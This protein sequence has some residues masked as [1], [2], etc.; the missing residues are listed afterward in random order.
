MQSC[1]VCVTLLS[2]RPSFHVIAQM[3]AL[4]SE[5]APSDLGGGCEDVQRY[6]CRVNTNFSEIVQQLQ[7]M[8]VAIKVRLKK[9]SFLFQSSEL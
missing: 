6:G 2:V 3:A 5:A 4:C 9:K 8:S 7:K 1:Y